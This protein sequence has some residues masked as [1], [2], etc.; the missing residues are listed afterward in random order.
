MKLTDEMYLLIGISMAKKQFYITHKEPKTIL[1]AV[2]APYNRNSYIRSY[3]EEFLNLVKTDGI[4]YKEMLEIKLRDI[5]PAT[6]FGKG[7]MDDI[8]NAC[9]EHNAEQVIISEQ[10]TPQQARNLED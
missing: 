2:N 6:F 1:V 8:K 5:N 9:R 3:F 7:K 10:L 4:P